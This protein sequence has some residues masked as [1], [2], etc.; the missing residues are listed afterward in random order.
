MDSQ[1]GRSKP[2]KYGD[3]TMTRALLLAAVLGLSGCG[4]TKD[5]MPHNHEFDFRSA[6]GLPVSHYY[7]YKSLSVC[8]CGQRLVRTSWFDRTEMQLIQTKRELGYVDAE[9][10]TM[11]R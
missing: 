9:T 1:K 3:K 2:T 4:K 8:K 11:F 7:L 10:E 6:D 5:P